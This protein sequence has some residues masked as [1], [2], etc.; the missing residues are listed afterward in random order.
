MGNG[1]IRICPIVL[2]IRELLKKKKSSKP[3][4]SLY[5]DF[6]FLQFELVVLHSIAF[7]YVRT[8]SQERM[9][10]RLNQMS[11]LDHSATINYR[12]LK[13]NGDQVRTTIIIK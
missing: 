6:F 5:F 9:G 2:R 12:V 8:T 10:L 1:D 13:T 7:T 4:L 3:T 11:Y